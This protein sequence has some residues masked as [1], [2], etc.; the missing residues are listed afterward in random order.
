MKVGDTI[1]SRALELNLYHKMDFW[2]IIR[3][4][5]F[6]FLVKGWVL[7]TLERMQ[8]TYSQSLHEAVKVVVLKSVNQ[9]YL[10]LYYSLI[11]EGRILKE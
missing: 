7:K 3:T 10:K 1:F 6:F 8:L 4:F 2:V 9:L 11:I 5:I